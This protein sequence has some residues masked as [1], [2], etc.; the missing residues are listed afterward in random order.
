MSVVDLLS[1]DDTHPPQH[2]RPLKVSGCAQLQAVSGFALAYAPPDPRPPLT[3]TLALAL[4]LRLTP[5]LTYTL[6]LALTLPL[7]RA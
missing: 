6:S 1:S 5:T 3:L 7:T 4:T 2:L